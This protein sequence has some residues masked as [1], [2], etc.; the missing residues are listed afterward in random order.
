M[1][2]R[3]TALLR[4]LNS[5]YCRTPRCSSRPHAHERLLEP[6]GGSLSSDLPSGPFFCP[7]PGGR[8]EFES[9]IS[10]PAPHPHPADPN[11][12]QG[13]TTVDELI[14][15]RSLLSALS[16][17][18]SGRPVVRNLQAAVAA[19]DGPHLPRMASRPVDPTC[20][21][22]P[23]RGFHRR[24]GPLPRAPSIPPAGSHGDQVVGRADG[25]QLR[26]PTVSWVV[27]PSPNLDCLNVGVVPY[28]YS[29]L[30]D[31][32][33]RAQ[34]KYARSASLSRSNLLA[35]ASKMPAALGVVEPVLLLLRVGVAPHPLH[36]HP[37]MTL[38]LVRHARQ[39][40]FG[41]RRPRH[42]HP[43]DG[44]GGVTTNMTPPTMSSSSQWLM[45]VRGTALHRLRLRLLLLVRL[46]L[47]LRLVLRL[48]PSAF[49]FYAR[50]NCGSSDLAGGNG[51][52]ALARRLPAPS[53]RPR[54]CSRMNVNAEGR[55]EGRAK[56]EPKA[57]EEK[58]TK[59]R[60][61]RR[62]AGRTSATGCCCSSWRGHVR[63]H[64]HPDRHSG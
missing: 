34:T 61:W 31:P 54:S 9:G 27:C 44:Q 12:A 58:K 35:A 43:G 33:S 6:A 17:L 3:R 13:A 11:D 14:A 24:S 2:R 21:W 30:C 60:R 62:A 52:P 59:R 23:S 47:V 26:L 57:D 10:S 1:R 55:A 63:R 29:T 42:D 64:H 4:C 15:S 25:G 45:Y 37:R 53:V 32:A 7:S 20:T 40:V 50:A 19:D 36:V 28:R 49:A 5:R 48:D 16:S 51:L 38:K 8:A 39:H 18:I 41:L 46:R 22:V 56:D